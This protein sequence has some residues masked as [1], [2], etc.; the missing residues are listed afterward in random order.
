MYNIAKTILA[1]DKVLKRIKD[2]KGKI[3]FPIYINSE[4]RDDYL[5]ALQKIDQEGKTELLQ[6]IIIKSMIKVMAELHESW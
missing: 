1:A 3:L 6:I 2:T 4:N 5:E